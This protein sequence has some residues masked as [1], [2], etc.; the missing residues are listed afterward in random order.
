MPVFSSKMTLF[1][2]A[3]LYTIIGMVSFNEMSL[4]KVSGILPRI[5]S[6]YTHVHLKSTLALLLSAYMPL[7]NG[8]SEV[9]VKITLQN[10]LRH[11]ARFAAK[12]SEDFIQ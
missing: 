6:N 3:G 5:I 8:N 11:L 2:K 7:K 12:H 1:G 9:P 4:Y 10:K